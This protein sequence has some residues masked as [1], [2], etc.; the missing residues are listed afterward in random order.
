LTC[1]QSGN[2]QQEYLAK[3][4]Y[5]L[6]VKVKKKNL[7]LLY[8]WLLSISTKYGN[9]KI[10]LKFWSN[11]GYF[12]VKKHMILS[13]LI[14]NIAFWLCTANPPKKKRLGGGGQAVGGASGSH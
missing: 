9:W 12:K 4:G 14:F 8:F 1:S 13:L 2:D 3:L 6:N 5:K 11:Y 7:I 10:F